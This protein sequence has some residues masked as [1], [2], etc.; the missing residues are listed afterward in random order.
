MA[1]HVF[2]VNPFQHTSHLETLVT[3]REAK[4]FVNRCRKSPDLVKG[5]T[6]RMMFANSPEQAEQLLKE[7]REPRPMGEHD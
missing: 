6:Y 5:T 1:Y 7:K 3:Y 4:E 2:E